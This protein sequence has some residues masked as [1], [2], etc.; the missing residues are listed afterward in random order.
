MVMIVGYYSLANRPVAASQLCFV[1]GLKSL[2]VTVTFALFV[3]LLV[4]SPPTKHTIKKTLL[5][6]I[7]I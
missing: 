7:A 5:V 3:I 4:I 6:F 2:Y 1:R